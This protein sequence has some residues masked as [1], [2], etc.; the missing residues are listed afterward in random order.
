MS[1][2]THARERGREREREGEREGE[3]EGERGG[4]GR[5][6]PGV[7]IP[8]ALCG[9]VSREFTQLVLAVSVLVESARAPTRRRGGWRRGEEDQHAR[10]V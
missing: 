9:L 8:L 1:A 5:E 4:K 7:D 3:G 2:R 6:R 10:R